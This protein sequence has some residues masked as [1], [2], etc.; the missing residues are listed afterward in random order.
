VPSL[1]GS[2][3]KLLRAKEHFDQLKTEIAREKEAILRAVLTETTYDPQTGHF[4]VRVVWAP[5]IPPRFSTIVGDIIHNLRSA[6]D[7]LAHQVTALHPDGPYDKSQWPIVSALSELKKVTTFRET[8]KLFTEPQLAIAKRH[9]PYGS[10]RALDEYFGRTVMP[11]ES[12]PFFAS[13]APLAWIRDFSN[14]D[15][16]RLLVDNF[17]IPEGQSITVKPIRDCANLSPIY[18]AVVPLKAG[19]EIAAFTADIT[20]SN[21]QMGVDLNFTP[22][23]GIECGRGMPTGMQATQSLELMAAKTLQIVREFEPFF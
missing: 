18:W 3:A 14:T 22:E 1:E 16:H 17:I 2:F 9:Q 20:G 21:P 10:I 4:V 11:D 23:I 13:T 8:L 5:P 7:H 12:L 15:K 19:T 6:L